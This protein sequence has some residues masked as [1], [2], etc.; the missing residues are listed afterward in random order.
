MD[1][2]DACDTRVVTAAAALRTKYRKTTADGKTLRCKL[3]IA[4]LGVHPKN[5]GGAYPSGV[6]CK[7]LLEDVLDAGLV[8]EE[9]N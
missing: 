1:K 9:I 2:S 4:N 7:A 3:R 6:R 8:K 5:R